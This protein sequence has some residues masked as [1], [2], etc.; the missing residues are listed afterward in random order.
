MEAQGQAGGGLEV[1]FECPEEGA[2]RSDG[3]SGEETVTLEGG[4]AVDFVDD[5]D[6]NG[7]RR[8]VAV[9]RRCMIF[10]GGKERHGNGG[11]Q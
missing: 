6:V 2:C 9:R 5:T 11:N 7:G 10:A 3:E 4:R 1:H 8:D